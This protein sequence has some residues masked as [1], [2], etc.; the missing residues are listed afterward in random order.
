MD[1]PPGAADYFR[2]EERSFAGGAGALFCAEKTGLFS[3]CL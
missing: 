1:K 2:A 3:I